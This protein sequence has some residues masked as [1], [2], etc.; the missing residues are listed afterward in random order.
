VNAID[1]LLRTYPRARVERLIR[2]RSH[3]ADLIASI[4]GVLL[5]SVHRD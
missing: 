5:S 1:E 3:I 4:A 2:G